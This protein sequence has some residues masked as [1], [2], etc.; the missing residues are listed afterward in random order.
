MIYTFYSYKGGVGR[1]TALAYVAQRLYLQGLRVLIVDWNL[2]SPGLES[3]FFGR[4]DEASAAE[5]SVTRSIDWV[6]DQ[7]GVM[8]MLVDYEQSFGWLPSAARPV[9][10]TEGKSELAPRERMPLAECLV[11]IH[12]DDG[13][14]SASGGGGSLCL[15]TAGRRSREH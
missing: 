5:G 3:F 9:S 12:P 2:R 6:Q 7:P 4:V 8:D 10:E 11:P 14:E 15:L 13:L 1:S